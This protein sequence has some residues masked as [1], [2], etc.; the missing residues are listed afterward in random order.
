MTP[1]SSAALASEP[2][3]TH[4]WLHRKTLDNW[5]SIKNLCRNLGKDSPSWNPIRRIS[6]V[7]FR[8]YVG[9]RTIT[10]SELNWWQVSSS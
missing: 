1:T 9:H 5:V 7:R 10:S 4:P 8:G 3:Q 6:M 2:E